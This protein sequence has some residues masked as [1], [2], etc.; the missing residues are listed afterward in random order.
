MIDI[1]GKQIVPAVS[2]YVG[3]LA[4]SKKLI[5]KICPKANVS[6]QKSIIEESSELLAKTKKAL[7]KLK[8]TLTKAEAIKGNRETAL[9][10]RSKVVPAM[11]ELRGPVDKLEM[12]VDKEI[13][14]MPSYG[15]LLF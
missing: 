11:A 3:N 10:Y 12:L 7:D 9:Y 2:T 5:E 6:T 13:W 14:P 1:A 4:E 8:R 15:D